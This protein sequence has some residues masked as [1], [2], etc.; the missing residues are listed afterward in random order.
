MA[1]N[2]KLFYEK[3]QHV[4]QHHPAPGSNQSTACLRHYKG[5]V[6]LMNASEPRTVAKAFD[7]AR[8]GFM[9]TLTAAAVTSPSLTHQLQAAGVA[10]V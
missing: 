6:S 2:K 5:S 7:L 4:L 10:V 3:W 1:T 9:V 8:H